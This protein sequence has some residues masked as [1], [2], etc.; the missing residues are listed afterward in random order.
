MGQE[1]RGEAQVGED[2]HGL[3]TDVVR[4]Y[5]LQRGQEMKVRRHH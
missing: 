2:R 1:G 4:D 3:E 5:V